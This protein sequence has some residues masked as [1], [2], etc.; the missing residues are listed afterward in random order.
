MHKKLT[1]IK[2]KRCLLPVLLVLI[3]LGGQPESMAQAWP[4]PYKVPSFQVVPA[5]SLRV[6]K[7]FEYKF[8]NKCE[9]YMNIYENR[10]FIY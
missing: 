6:S 5:D 3:L 7:K 8:D 9:K 4:I 2:K 10:R 1:I